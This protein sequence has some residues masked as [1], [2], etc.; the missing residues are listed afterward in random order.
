MNKLYK[1]YGHAKT[2]LKYHI[3]FSTKYRRKCLTDIR[4]IVISSFRYVESKSDFEIMEM[5]LD[6]D[7]IHLLLEFKPSLSIQSVVNRLKS[8]STNYLYKACSQYLHNFYWSKNELWTRGYFCST[9]G[10]VS[11]KTL[12]HYIRNQG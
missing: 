9:I 10:D 8:M 2:N 5:E 4:D 11:Q 6:K 12:I 1:T 7:H 3:I